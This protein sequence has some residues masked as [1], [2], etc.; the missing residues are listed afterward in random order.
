M[1]K[2]V[3]LTNRQQKALETRQRLLDAGRAVFLKNGFQKATM[4]E[5]NKVAKTG[6]GTAYVYFKNKDELFIEL[7]ER[8]MQKMYDVAELPFQPESKRAASEQIKE[9]VIRFIESA[10]EEKKAMRI[11][12]EAIGVSQAVEDKWD[13]IKAHFIKRISEDIHYVQRAG[14]VRSDVDPHVVAKSWFYLNEQHMW[15]FVLEKNVAPLQD[16][17]ENLVTFYMEGIYKSE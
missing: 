5:I 7:I 4:T 16:V 8:I 14:L 9:Q 11:I 15:D 10:L 1:G 6:H 2:Q 12:K 3:Q 17:A 13:L